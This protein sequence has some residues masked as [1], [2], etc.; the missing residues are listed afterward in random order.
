MAFPESVHRVYILKTGRS[1]VIV[2]KGRRWDDLFRH[3]P[4]ATEDFMA[5]RQQPAAEDR[6]KL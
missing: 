6:E 1:R 3:G 5:E 4:R 2:T